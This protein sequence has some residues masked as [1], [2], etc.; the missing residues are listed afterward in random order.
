MKQFII[1]FAMIMLGIAIYGMIAGSD[2][3]SMLSSVKSLWS[4]EI[5]LRTKTP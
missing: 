3:T 2:D 4:Q 1:L 5:D